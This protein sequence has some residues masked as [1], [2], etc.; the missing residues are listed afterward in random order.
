MIKKITALVLCL[1]MLFSVTSYAATFTDVANDGSET[2][3]AIGVLNELGVISG[4][5]DGT[6]SPYTS[7]TRAQVAKIAVCIMGKTNEAVATTDAF[8]DVKSTHWYSG[9]VN[10]V[11]KEG[12]ITGYP[13]GSFGA[14][15]PITY[16]QMVTILIRL[17]GYDASDVGHKWP[18][19][20]IDKANV[21]GITKGLSL[22]ANDV[23]NRRD[24]ALVIYR[25]LFTD[26]KGTKSA[27]VTKMDKNVYED[28][29][30]VATSNENTALLS[31][32]VQTLNGTFKYDAHVIDMTSFVGFEG[33]MV[34]NDDAEIIAF[35]PAEDMKKSLYTV[36]AV[37]SESS[38]KSVTVI[39]DEGN[40]SLDNNLTV[41]SE[42]NIKTAASL[43]E[44]VTPG[45]TVAVFEVNGAVKH[46]VVSE[47]KYAGPVVY[48]AGS[49]F[50]LFDIAD[51]KNVKI[52]R[53][54]ISADTD[55]ITE[56]DVLY[57]SERT[58]TV[59][60]YT[61]RVTGMYEEAYPMKSN[62]TRVTVSGKEYNLST[63]EAIN[64]LNESENAFKIGD[65]VTLLFGMDGSVVAAVSLTDTD[66]SM[67][68]VL[69]GTGMELS[70]DEDTKGRTEHYVS[71]LHANGDEVKYTV[72]DDSYED[73]AGE[74]CIVDFENSFATLTFPQKLSVSGYVNK[75]TGTIGDK[76]LSSDVKILEYVSGDES[77]ARVAKVSV[78]DL[79]G[80]TLTKKDV[81]N[82]VYN[83]KGE[84][85]LLYLDNVTGNE[86]IYGVVIADPGS[87]DGKPIKQGTYTILSN[88]TKYTVNGTFTSLRK[89]DSVEYIKNGQD[90][91]VVELI[92][93]GE[94]HG[95]E[96]C[97]DNIIVVGN[98]SYTLADNATIYV[99]K[100]PA[101]LK[102]VS[103]EDAVG[104][105]GS[106]TLYSDKGTREGGKVRV[107]II[108]TM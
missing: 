50:T 22:N 95:V 71:V 13:D 40:I 46:A 4:M 11:A 103:W 90:T 52:I 92:R 38:A 86:G 77:S 49:I 85:V 43:A 24:A 105:S 78:G 102:S 57:Y 27:L 94:G 75:D 45:S 67:Y 61:D 108:Y 98:D 51:K 42:G 16:A 17:L 3:E 82:V 20:Y 66:V 37:Y 33:T 41:Y 99:G 70:D 36:A 32:Q 8:S 80:M 81:L 54:G 76:K 88:N 34:V 39:A 68:G 87:Q 107:V 15:D 30:V 91:E 9:Y 60:A 21:L 97:I 14:N 5:G 6:F 29:I 26:M 12:V 56:Y 48:T 65:R 74:M 44:G 59:Y 100:T 93:V 58:N 62:V 2:S 25:A 10:T 96:E 73:M 83:K 53:D 18:Q 72:A 104:I 23:I 69:L 35:V 55:D 79:W 106:I 84:I 31:N 101:E 1:A 7:L 19:G 63:L 47:Y 28:A 64:K 89:G